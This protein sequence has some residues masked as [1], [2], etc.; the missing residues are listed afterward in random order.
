MNA[1][2]KTNQIVACA[3]LLAASTH[4]EGVGIAETEI[5]PDASA[6]F[7]VASTN[8]GALFPRMT[9]AQREAI[10][11][12]AVGLLVYDT[13]VDAFFYRTGS[14]WEK[15]S[16]SSDPV[17]SVTAFAGTTNNIPDGWLLCDGSELSSSNYPSLYAAIGI[18]WG[19]GSNGVGTDFNVPDMRGQFLRGLNQG[20]SDGK[21]DPDGGGRSVGSYQV[22]ALQ[23]MT[24]EFW[25]R[26]LRWDSRLSDVGV[27]DLVYDSSQ[28]GTGTAN[29]SSASKLIFDSARVARSSS[30]T[31]P[32]NVSVN[33]IIKY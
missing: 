29:A 9:T 30:E 15:I 6:M 25:H 24:G 14:G 26:Q 22:D 20:R 16:S 11:S 7:E 18:A 23:R 32:K 21:Q 28:V 5:T 1:F 31:R 10:L 4:A 19:D 2:I 17:G 13:D 8:K 12:P 3:V 33:Y 27:F